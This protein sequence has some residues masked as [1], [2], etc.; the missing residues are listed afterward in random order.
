MDTKA[1]EWSEDDGADERESA[2]PL[3]A[4]ERG[5][6]AER[7]AAHRRRPEDVVTWASAEKKI[8]RQ[9]GLPERK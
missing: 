1:H 6:I 2:A 7:V 5:L 9:L 4:W 3:T 8:R